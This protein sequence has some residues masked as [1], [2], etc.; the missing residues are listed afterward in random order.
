MQQSLLPGDEKVGNSNANRFVLDYPEAE[1][2]LGLVYAVGTDYKPVLDYLKD[3]IRPSGYAADDLRISD[4]FPESAD[5]LNLNI[6]LLDSTEYERIASRIDAG[7]KIRGRTKQSDIFALI[8]AS[9]IFSSREMDAND[10]PVPFKRRAHILVSLKRP[11][12]VEALRK[13][14]GPGF[15]LIGIFADESQRSDFLINRKGLT[16][17]QADS[18]IRRDQ[19]EK[20]LEHGQRTRDTFQMADLFVGLA[21][22]EYEKGLQRFLRLVFGDPFS[23]PT[24]DEHA[25]FLAYVRNRS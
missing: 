17:E 25:M 14:Y 9:K 5:R 6:E 3:Q 21:N 13:I 24:K 20:E 1:L 12:E 16:H 10:N 8:A 18:L 22:N 7:N 11:E 23:T 19:K 15:F 4:W 2:V